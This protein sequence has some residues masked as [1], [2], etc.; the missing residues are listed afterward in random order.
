MLKILAYCYIPAAFLFSAANSDSVID[1]F[2]TLMLGA[3]YIATCAVFVTYMTA[4]SKISLRKGMAPIYFATVKEKLFRARSTSMRLFLFDSVVFAMALA[5][6]TRIFYRNDFHSLANLADISPL[7][8]T[9]MSLFT[10]SYFCYCLKS[11]QDLNFE[12]DE[13]STEER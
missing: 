3:L 12:I 8:F 11:L 5:G 7:F 6:K 10:L 13:R 2:S 1:R 4:F 9:L